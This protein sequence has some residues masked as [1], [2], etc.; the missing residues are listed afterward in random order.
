MASQWRQEHGPGR[1]AGGELRPDGAG[2][3]AGSVGGGHVQVGQQAAEGPSTARRT[4]VAID[5]RAGRDD[6][7]ANTRPCDDVGDQGGRR[8][9]RPAPPPGDRVGDAPEPRAVRRVPVPAG[10]ARRRG[11]GRWAADPRRRRAGAA[12]PGRSAPP[13]PQRPAPADPAGQRPRTLR[14][15]EEHLGADRDATATRGPGP[16]AGCRGRRPSSAGRDGRTS[17]ATGAGRPD[18]GAGAVRR[19][20]ATSAVG[21]RGPDVPLPQAYGERL[22]QFARDLSQPPPR[23]RRSQRRATT[24]P[25]G[26]ALDRPPLE[27]LTAQLLDQRLPAASERGA[28]P[29]EPHLRRQRHSSAPPAGRS[30]P[31]QPRPRL[32]GRRQRP[33]SGRTERPGRAPAPPHRALVPAGGSRSAGDLVQHRQ[34]TSAQAGG[35]QRLCPVLLDGGADER[36]PAASSTGRTAS[37]CS[38][39]P[40][41][42]ALQK[43]GV[44][45][46]ATRQRRL[47]AEPHRP[48]RRNGQCRSR[49]GTDARRP[50]AR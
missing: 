38:H 28:R 4:E 17:S 45:E 9:A 2:H 20:H 47:D 8:P 21:Q 23:L 16:P 42:L 13:R 22:A 5:G 43:T 7:A 18:P 6:S 39:R 49:R 31:A 12:P 3:T 11:R 26:A 36:R 40:D 30:G 37:M 24:P 50:R 1:R 19:R 33:R 15:L 14:P 27:A 44:A 34:A 35:H 29:P 10:A 48:R 32:P 41:Q 25:R 46:V